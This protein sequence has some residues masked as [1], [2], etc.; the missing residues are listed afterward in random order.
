MCVPKIIPLILLVVTTELIGTVWHV[1][2]K[3]AHKSTIYE[4]EQTWLTWWFLSVFIAVYSRSN[5]VRLPPRGHN[6]TGLL[7]SLIV[8]MGAWPPP[9]NLGLLKSYTSALIKRKSYDPLTEVISW[10]TLMRRWWRGV[11]LHRILRGRRE[12]LQLINHDIPFKRWERCAILTVQS[13]ASY[14]CSWERRTGNIKNLC[15]PVHR[16]K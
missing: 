10:R 13:L 15:V 3:T 4:R 5:C 7:I 12:F 2:L 9:S 1:V 16:K 6:F 8:T 14:P 11:S